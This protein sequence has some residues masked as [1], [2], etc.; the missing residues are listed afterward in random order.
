MLGQDP[1]GPLRSVASSGK[2]SVKTRLVIPSLVVAATLFLTG[3]FV[4]SDQKPLQQGPVSDEALVGDWRAVDAESGKLLNAFI[5]IQKTEGADPLRVIYVEDDDYA[6]Y[7]LATTQAG[8]RKVFAMKALEPEDARKEI[9]T[10]YM[11][12]FYEVVG[13]EVRFHLLDAEKV[14]ELIKQGKL[15]GTAGAKQYDG[16]RLSGPSADITKFLAS[17]EGWNTRTDDPARMRRMY[18]EK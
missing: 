18:P 6:I 13:E 17:N 11:L 8:T 16:A 2:I 14:G 10:G 12:G 7:E 15:S 4:T 9:G 3:C 5:H 1:S